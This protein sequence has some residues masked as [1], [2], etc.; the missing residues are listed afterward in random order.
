MGVGAAIATGISSLIGAGV[1]IDSNN[2]AK[3]Q[4]RRQ[5]AEIDKQKQQE[6]NKRKQLIDEQR[7]NLLGGGNGSNVTT[8]SGSYSLLNNNKT[9]G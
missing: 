7:Y 3:K 1:S 4:A 6:L 5:Q 9:L 8:A 2:E